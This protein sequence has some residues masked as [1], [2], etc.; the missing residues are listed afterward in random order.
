MQ[1]TA[2]EFLECR[3][4]LFNVILQDFREAF[5]WL[6]CPR[7]DQGFFLCEQK[8]E[9]LHWLLRRIV[10]QDTLP[11]E[12]DSEAL[13]QK[14]FIET[15]FLDVPSFKEKTEFGA[16]ALRVVKSKTDVERER[17]KRQ[18]LSEAVA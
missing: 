14:E 13:R 7:R 8:L 5:K 9:F 12:N 2:D 11:D 3:L 1:V 4:E 6:S 18:K 10:E 17:S 16:E 15:K